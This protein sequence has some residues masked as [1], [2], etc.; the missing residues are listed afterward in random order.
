MINRA[1]LMGTA[2]IVSCIMCSSQLF[3]APLTASNRPTAVAMSVKPVT[4]P[5]VPK[6]VPANAG[7]R[8]DLTNASAGLGKEPSWMKGA[9]GAGVLGLGKSSEFGKIGAPGGSAGKVKEGIANLKSS[10][11][12]AQGRDAR[13]DISPGNVTK[14]SKGI[15]AAKNARGQAQGK[16]GGDTVSARNAEKIAIGVEAAKDSRGQALGKQASDT[17]MRLP[18]KQVQ[19]IKDSRTNPVVNPSLNRDSDADN[20]KKE[21]EKKLIVQTVK[22][23]VNPPKDPGHKD[24]KTGAVISNKGGTIVF[25][26]QKIT[27]NVPKPPKPGQ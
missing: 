17:G 1:S 11:G 15:A 10:H 18:A 3:A 22:N 4:V 16:T 6:Y 2:A 25:P 27:A 8:N 5:T 14:V 23:L 12:Q 7:A 20:Q 26:N 13:D 21:A 19:A 9:G 24:P